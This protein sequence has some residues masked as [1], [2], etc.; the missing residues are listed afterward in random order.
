M[1]TDKNSGPSRTVRLSISGKQTDPEGN[2]QENTALHHAICTADGGGWLFT[3]MENGIPARLYISRSLAWME[4]GDLHREGSSSR[5]ESAESLRGSGSSG[6]GESESLRG[7]GSSRTEPAESLRGSGSS[8]AG[9]S[10]SLRGSGSSGTEPAESLRGS[11][12]S[13]AGESESLRDSGG[14]RMVFD[15]AL[16]AARCMYETPFGRIPML[17]RTEGIALLGGKKQAAPF[18]LTARI[19][20]TLRMDPDYTLTCAVT[21]RAV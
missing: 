6:A 4:R 5:T 1:R 2:T 15:P 11:G 7:S 19:R 8:G 3:Y 16:S 21:I 17:I 12:S 9:E 18:R 14:T 20:Y 13:G 10:E